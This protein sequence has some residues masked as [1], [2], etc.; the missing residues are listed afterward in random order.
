MLSYTLGN[1]LKWSAFS[2]GL[3]LYNCAYSLGLFPNKY[4][5]EIPKYCD[6]QI[7][8]CQKYRRVAGQILIFPS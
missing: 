5:L 3:F 4:S 6:T 8:Y 2:M 1:C 7:Q